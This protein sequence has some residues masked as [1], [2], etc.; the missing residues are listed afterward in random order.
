M[1]WVNGERAADSRDG[2]MAIRPAT[3]A[4]KRHRENPGSP[5]SHGVKICMFVKNSFEYDARVTKEAETLIAAG[6]DVTVVALHAPETTV[7]RETTATGIE[8]VRVSRSNL[9]GPGLNRMATTYGA[10]IE[11]RHARLTGNAVD[12]DR[13]RDHGTIA[14]PSTATPGDA[15][16]RAIELPSTEADTEVGSAHKAW[17]KVTTPV[18]RGVPEVAKW[19]YRTAKKALGPQ[20]RRIQQR[21]IDKRM[22]EAGLAAGATVFHS[23]DLNTLRVGAQCK[24]AVPGSRL[25]Y[26]SHELQTERNRMTDR[27]RQVATNTERSYIGTADAMIVASPSWIDWNRKLYGAVP[28]P[29]ITI[30]NVPP[31]TPVDRSSLFRDEL[32]IDPDQRILLYQGS[33]QENRG[34]E[35][36]IDA[37]RLLDDVVLVVVGYG[38]HKP[39]LE[40]FVASEGLGDRV[41][42]YGAIPNADL[43]RYTASADIGLANIVNSSVSY[44]T[45]LPNKLFEY[46][47]ADIP[48]VGSDSPEIGRIVTGQRIG[49]ICDPES[50][51]SIA[52]AVKTILSD[53]TRYQTGLADTRERYNWDVEGKK[54]AALYELLPALPTS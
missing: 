16:S 3:G 5:Y 1:S 52:S 24:A 43:I 31:P 47:M 6:H 39:F 33:I 2:A 53:P 7:Q 19:G 34:I 14:T 23:H 15:G 22:I 48:V 32:G 37:V 26:D 27:E 29:S 42:F 40:S 49:E 10:K 45:S 18:L 8:V 21:A 30:L 13:I 11:T 46:A 4:H 51:T 36:A 35:P 50:P 12:A 54:L 44:H 25:V 9:G 38:H 41:L 28:D 17:A 20:A